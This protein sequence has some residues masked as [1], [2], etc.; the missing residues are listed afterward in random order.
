MSPCRAVPVL[1]LLLGLARATTPAPGGPTTPGQDGP[2]TTTAALDGSFPPGLHTVSYSDVVAAA[3]ELLNARAVSPYVL[4]LGGAQ[5]QP[6]QVGAEL[7]GGTRT[8]SAW[9]LASF[10]AEFGSFW[11]WVRPSAELEL[12]QLGVDREPPPGWTWSLLC[13]WVGGW[14]WFLLGPNRARFGAGALGRGSPTGPVSSLSPW[15]CG[16]GSS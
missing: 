13:S 5:P 4:Q 6:S 14:I 3:V 11:G 2:T 1:L 7:R 8:L 16:A 15:T 10:W 9:G 12:T